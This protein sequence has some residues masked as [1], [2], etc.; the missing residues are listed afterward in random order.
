MKRAEILARIGLDI[1]L[2]SRIRLLV[3]T[4]AKNEADDQYAIMHHLLTPMFDIR[5]I[6]A[7]HFEQKAG[8][9][10]NSMEKSYREIEKLL[11][12]AQIVDAVA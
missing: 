6:I 8:G 12:L 1:P 2:A 9:A 5:G 11:G 10:G 7:A 4:D 3:D